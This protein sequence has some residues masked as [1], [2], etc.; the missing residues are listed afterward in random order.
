MNK[1]LQKLFDKIDVLPVVRILQ[2]V[3]AII[4]MIGIFHIL[5]LFKQQLFGNFTTPRWNN[6]AD[7]LLLA[8]MTLGRIL[9]EPTILLAL[10][11]II[12]LMRVKN[13]QN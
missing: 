3:A 12:K 4:F 10:A 7:A 5:S 2:A 9:F 1:K 13:D 11:E 8:S 6:L